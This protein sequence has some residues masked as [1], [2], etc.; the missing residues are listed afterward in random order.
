MN[1]QTILIIVIAAVV[2]V[3]LLLVAWA[4]NRRR[5]TEL[6][7]SR[8]GPEY[9]RTVRDLGTSR[10]EQT[11][12]DRARRVEKLRIRELTADYCVRF[13]TDRQHLHSLSV[14]LPHQPRT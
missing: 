9:E 12:L 13:D 7:Q 4:V 6:L 3:G 8:F 10:A 14:Q 1:Q 11:L 2:V 5:Q